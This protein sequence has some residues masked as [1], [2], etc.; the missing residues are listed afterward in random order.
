VLLAAFITAGVTAELVAATINA[1]SLPLESFWHRIELSSVGFG[2]ITQ[3]GLVVA[4]FLLLV[5][6]LAAGRTLGVHGA[7][8]PV[9]GALSATGVLANLTTMIGLLADNSSHQIGLSEVGEGDAVVVTA[10]LAPT[11]LAA[12]ALWLVFFALRDAQ[13]QSGQLP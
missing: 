7:M 5:D 6:C 4:A 8:L 13:S 11:F 1:S 10:Y 2:V 3:L 12:L 9:V